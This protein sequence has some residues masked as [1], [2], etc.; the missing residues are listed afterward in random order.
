MIR[1]GLLCA[2]F[3]RDVLHITDHKDLRQFRSFDRHPLRDFKTI[4]VMDFTWKRYNAAE[5]AK[6]FLEALPW[7]E[8]ILL[9]LSTEAVEK[10]SLCC[11]MKNPGDMNENGLRKL[12]EQA[13][14]K[15]EEYSEF[16]DWYKGTQE[17]VSCIG[18]NGE[19]H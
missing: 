3:D 6:Y 5:Y 19:Y 16:L 2:N 9:V 11:D 8:K 7:V 12:K 18:Y 1:A 4:M 15:R 10:D 13:T 17:T 14:D